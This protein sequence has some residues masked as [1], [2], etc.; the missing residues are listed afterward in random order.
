M[1]LSP[2]V[3]ALIDS[4]AKAAGPST[5][6]KRAVLSK[7]QAATMA[8]SAA[9]V[10]PVAAHAGV[11]AGLTV[12]LAVAVV[13]LSVVGAVAWWARPAT[14]PTAPVPTAPAPTAPP[15]R[16]EVVVPQVVPAA[17]VVEQ[18]VVTPTVAAPAPAKK[19][20]VAED[21][22]ALQLDALQRALEALEAGRGAD[23]VRLAREAH[24]RWPRGAFAVE[25][26]VIE[27]LGLCA[28]GAEDEA[29][30]LAAQL[31]AGPDNPAL[32]R[33]RNSCAK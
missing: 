3:R 8:L 9:P 12:K 32:A 10:A 33:L 24:A 13:G 2:D 6:Q 29:R 14:A 31:R 15:T 16:P 25:T 17:P 28:E 1:S 22:F 23:A 26:Q 11:K 19:R 7:V 30:A 18:P 21:V 27:V 5:A 20:E 4:A